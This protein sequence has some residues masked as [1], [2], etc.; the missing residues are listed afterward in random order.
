MHF[1]IEFSDTRL[2]LVYPHVFSVCSL[3]QFYHGMG[4]LSSE[5]F[6]SSSLVKKKK[7]KSLSTEILHDFKH[8]WKILKSVFMFLY[9]IFKMSCLW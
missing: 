6:I 9:H 2:H 7:K 8:W 1:P 5:T 4:L 3:D